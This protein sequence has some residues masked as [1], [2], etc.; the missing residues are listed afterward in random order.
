MVEAQAA[1]RCNGHLRGCRTKRE[2]AKYCRCDRWCFFSVVKY[3]VVAGID[4]SCDLF[5]VRILLQL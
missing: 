3:T 2:S 1:E 4:A 5:S